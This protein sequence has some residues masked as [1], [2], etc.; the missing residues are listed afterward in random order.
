MRI[1]NI[2]QTIFRVFQKFRA[3]I[4]NTRLFIVQIVGWY[5]KCNAEVDSKNKT[6]V[7]HPEEIWALLMKDKFWNGISQKHFTLK[8]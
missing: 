3:L 2:M 7:K 6:N 4:P 8:S 1:K 5:C